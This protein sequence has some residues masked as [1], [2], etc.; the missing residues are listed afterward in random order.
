[1][2]ADLRSSA[3]AVL[4]GNDTGRWTVPSKGQYPHQWNWDSAFCSLGWATFDWPRACAEIEGLLEAQWSDGMVPHVRYDDAHL[5]DYFPGPDRWSRA[6]ARVARAGVLTSGMSNPPMLVLAAWRCGQ[7]QAEREPRLAFW[8]RVH[9]PL[10]AW[11]RW[12]ASVRALPGSPLPCV[13]HPWETGWD[14]SPRWDSVRGAQLRP[15][16]PYRRLDTA[17]VGASERPSD[18]DYD[19]Y[20]AL[21]ER[22]EDADFD[23][24]RYL[25]ISPFVFH[26]VLI[27]AMWHRCAV[28][29]NAMARE[30]GRPE[31]FAKDTL[32]AFAAAFEAAHWCEDLSTYVDWDCQAGGQVRRLTAAGVASLVGGIASSERAAATW[33]A[34]EAAAAGGRL[35]PSLPPGDP[36]FDGRRYWRGPVWAPVNWLVIEG[37]RAAGMEAEASRLRGQTLQ[38]AES[39]FAENYDPRD[40]RPCGASGFSWTAAVTLDLLAGPPSTA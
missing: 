35:V 7:R 27:D 25:A 1:M 36:E 5:A 3:E 14:N 9:D 39:G 30:I 22:L 29:L 18:R 28:L 8:R 24:E 21:I 4:R 16:V 10:V 23:L 6:Q 17:H 37:L 2:N 15:R 11:I 40:G 20:I 19:A 13:V 32:A 33:A 38:L 34:Q 26:D 12:F 31:P